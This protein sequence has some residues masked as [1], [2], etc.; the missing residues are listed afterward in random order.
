MNPTYVYTCF[1]C[2]EPAYISANIIGLCNS[3]DQIDSLNF[4]L[5]F[6]K[7]SPDHRSKHSINRS[8]KYIDISDLEIPLHHFLHRCIMNSDLSA[9]CYPFHSDTLQS[10]VFIK[11]QTHAHTCTMIFF[12]L[13]RFG[14]YQYH[15]SKP[16]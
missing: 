6:S 12:S 8:R 16:L 13:N 10:E 7:Y 5:Y 3:S 1:L 2:H 14:L 4:T 15:E 9:N 11:T